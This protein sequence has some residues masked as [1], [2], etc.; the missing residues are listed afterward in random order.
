MDWGYLNENKVS[1]VPK[2][3][4]SACSQGTTLDYIPPFLTTNTIAYV[5]LPA[6]HERQLYY[7]SWYQAITYPADY[8][9]Y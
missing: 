5:T 6:W 9:R 8:I 3:I 1:V 7:P 4:R 2:D